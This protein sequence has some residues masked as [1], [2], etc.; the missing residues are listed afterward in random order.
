MK[1]KPEAERARSDFFIGCQR[2]DN[3]YHARVGLSFASLRD[4]EIRHVSGDTV[5]GDEASRAF[6]SVDSSSL[7]DSNEDTCA[8]RARFEFLQ[9]SRVFTSRR[10]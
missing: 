2:E 5:S 9:S 10:M 1:V 7:R 8:V 4:S 6:Y 3:A